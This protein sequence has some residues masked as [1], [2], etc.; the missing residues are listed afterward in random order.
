MMFVSLKCGTANVVEDLVNYTLNT[1]PDDAR[2]NVWKDCENGGPQPEASRPRNSKQ[3]KLGILECSNALT[4]TMKDVSDALN[5]ETD[6]EHHKDH[7]I[8][9]VFFTWLRSN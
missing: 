4:S 6:N 5:G 9:F 7:L 2:M 1:L 3:R 8:H